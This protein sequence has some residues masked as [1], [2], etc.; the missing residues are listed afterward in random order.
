M[1][2]IRPSRKVGV[3]A[4]RSGQRWSPVPVR[5]RLVW[6]KEGAMARKT[7]QRNLLLL[8]AGTLAF[9][10]CACTPSQVKPPLAWVAGQAARIANGQD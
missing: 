4:K 7:V 10:L 1:I 2:R 3:G 5:S 8:M 9:G 6:F